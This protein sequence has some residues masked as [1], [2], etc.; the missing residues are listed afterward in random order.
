MHTAKTVQHF[1]E[2]TH[3]GTEPAGP[4]IILDLTT[5]PTGIAQEQ[6]I[7]NTVQFILNKFFNH[8]SK[9]RT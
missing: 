2:I 5:S 6:T 8:A 9:H 3:G 7:T 4:V 1:M